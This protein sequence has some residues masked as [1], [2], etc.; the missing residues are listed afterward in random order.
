MTKRVKKNRIFASKYT[1]NGRLTLLLQKRR[2]RIWGPQ[3]PEPSVRSTDDG[4]PILDRKNFSSSTK[5]YLRERDLIGVI[6]THL[7]SE[8]CFWLGCFPVSPARP[9]ICSASAAA[10]RGA[11]C[12]CSTLTSPQYMNSTMALR[13]Q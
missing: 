12:S 4:H 10:S 13:A 11:S 3:K 1:K 7:A 5:F 9:L 6:L 8:F 2:F